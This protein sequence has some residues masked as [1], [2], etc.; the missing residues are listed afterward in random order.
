MPRT[1]CPHSSG[2]SLSHITQRLSALLLAC[3]IVCGL[4]SLAASKTHAQTFND[5]GFVTE[6]LTTLPPYKPVG[7]T[8]APDGRIFIWQENG[9]VRIYKNGAL[10]P[11]PFVNLQPH[12]NTFNDRGLLGMA[13]DPSFAT[14]G[15][16][17]LLY[18]YEEGSDPNS[19]TPKTARL[20]RVKADPANPDVALAGSETVLLGSIGVPPCSNY[21]AGADCIPSDSDT[22]TIGTLRF[23][24]DGK[25]FVS[26]GDG[27]GYVDADPL[28]LRA[29]NLDSYSGKILRINRDGSA[30]GDN[31]FDDGTNSVRSKVYAY[32]LR[33]P[34]RFTL[35]P[36]TGELFL[37]D[38]GWFSFEEIN[39]GR[40]ANFGWPC[41][42]GH[43]PQPL[44][45]AAFEQCREMSPGAVTPPLYTYDHMEGN[46]VIGGSFYTGT[47]YPSQYRGNY[48]FADYGYGFI[49]RMSFDASGQMLGVQEFVHD[50]I[51]PVSLE[52]GPDGLLYYISLSTGEV[53]RIRFEGPVAKA[54]ATPRWGYSPLN[55][56][57]SSA[58]SLDPGGGQLSYHWE[59][60]DGAS[61]NVANPAHTY[62]SATARTFEAVLTVTDSQMRSAADRVTVTVGSTPPTATITT[63]A[64][65]TAVSPGDVVNFQGLATDMDETL[66]PSALAWTVLLHHNNHVHPSTTASGPGGSFMVESHGEGVYSYELILTATDSSGL[67]NSKSVTLPVSVSHLPA[68]W[69]N[70]DIGTTGG[71]A[72][73]ANGTFIVRGAGA[74]IWDVADAFHY[75]YQP[76]NGDGEI[77]ARVASVTNT[78]P[79]AKGGI[80]IREA[81][82]SNARHAV[83]NVTPAAGLEFMRRRTTGGTT[84]YTSGGNET[85]P[86]WLKLVRAGNN[87]SA[88]KS[89]NGVNWTLIGTDTINMS[90]Q[91]YIGL[92]VSSHEPTALCSATFESLSVTS[93]NQPPSV[94]ITN[95]ASGA[96]F[97]VPAVITI[98]AAAS[99]ADGQLSRVDFYAGATLIGTDAT[100]PYS[101]TW[102]N[103]SPGSYAL[104]AKAT[105]NLGASTTS[106]VV[107]IS[108][109]G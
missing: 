8:F 85:A 73:Y 14:N 90:T 83:L 56:S 22:H 13:L 40:G 61:S 27:A 16:V 39:R 87:F 28:A 33:N 3:G 54:G 59:F 51:A 34:Y 50:L 26:I 67:S 109:N 20:T 81:L 42:E 75:V 86:K 95:P 7:L 98:E 88:Y 69:I 76:L 78:H 48:F 55:V 82:V 41:Y 108:V 65:G 77:I 6:L 47:Q 2:W 66:P 10:L 60:G 92:A 45:Q 52:M 23:A 43:L 107:N 79:S 103:V 101:L 46:S 64:N 100:A 84:E 38:V 32:G 80:M 12:V 93:I 104:T 57:L 70:Q 9:V 105:D 36:T 62:T 68:P 17:Y 72:S 4:I 63:P 25:L 15:Y 102:N 29:Q 53:R 1:A 21:P 30:P 24:P 106:A 35:Q 5:P 74:D 49:R 37:G 89:N 31:P 44:Y 71:S 91:A 19:M 99:D 94:S 18:T 97:N 11:T 96:A 58:G